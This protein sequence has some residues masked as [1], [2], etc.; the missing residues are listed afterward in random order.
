MDEGR[1]GRGRAAAPPGPPAGGASAARS[2]TAER[3]LR[4]ALR[5]FAERGYERT[6][7]ADI[8]GAVGLRPS[9]GALYKHYPSKEAL[10][11]AGVERFA[12]AGE[13]ARA[14]LGQLPERPEEALE[15]IGREVLAVL[16]AEADEVRLVWRELAQFPE[17]QGRARG[18]MQASYA[19][20]GA[21]LRERAARGELRAADPEATAAVLLGSLT[22]FRV[23]EILLGA[24]PAAVDDER[25][26]RAWLE[27]VTG[28]LAREAP[29]RAAPRD[30]ARPPEAGPET[31]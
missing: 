3:L 2:D 9:S 1:P 4:E 16:G 28:G 31:A 24:R 13:R 23:F 29:V 5:L 6:S 21:W 12:D 22:M 30:P 25:F 20:L 17:L 14:W 15:R 19:A 18:T 11:R 26:L 8:Q 7:I 27:L 10:L